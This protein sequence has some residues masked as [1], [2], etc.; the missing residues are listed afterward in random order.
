[1]NALSDEQTLKKIKYI[2]DK[3]KI[4]YKIL[5][6]GTDSLKLEDQ[7]QAL[8]MKYRE[9][10]STLLY[11]TGDGRFIAVFRRDDRSI[12]NIRLKQKL[13][14]S[15]LEYCNKKDLQELGF[16]EGLLSPFLLDERVEIYV[17]EAVM[18][19]TRIVC[20]SAIA[21]M[22]VETTRNEFLKFLEG[23]DHH[24]VEISFPNPHRQDIDN[25]QIRTVL[26]GITPSGSALHIGNYFG[27]VKPQMD[28][29]RSVEHSFY[30]VADLH[31]LTTVQDRDVL[32]HNI[33]NN[34]LDFIALGL[35][36]EKSAYFRQSD[37]PAHSQ[38]AIVLAN[39]IPFSF[40]KRMH[41]FKDKLEEGVTLN[42]INMGLFNYPILMAADILLYNPEGVPVGDDQ[43]QHV[44][45]T[46]DIAVRFN[47]TY[48]KDFF[49][50]P[51]P[52][53]QGGHSARVIGT[54]GKRKMSKS[55]NNVIGIF[56]DEEVIKKQIMGCYTDPN[57]KKITDPGTVEG[58]PVFIYH[59]LINEDREEVAELKERY[60]TGKVGDVEVKQRL[61]EAHKR[62]FAEAR[63]KRKEIAGDINLVK[64]VLRDG[65]R[66]AS[67]VAE[68]N[69]EKVYEVIGI[70]NSLSLK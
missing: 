52:L 39:Y 57:R 61:I 31:A 12:D 15:N 58:N 53:I 9:G 23:R 41:A 67:E 49:I 32:E 50:L 18:D 27:A 38:L 46:R 37:V 64:D 28:L 5:E 62:R 13:K 44:E 42:A 22:A 63:E 7:I 51:E 3:K 60:R 45:L 47:K 24:I 20:G 2:L 54:D 36:P 66:K 35:D 19:M 10:M 43:R 68:K 21:S 11:K 1:M 6:S 25:I 65:A 70:K 26:S 59:D 29:Q 16:R 4:K 8:N 48:D 17:T 56:E 33:E 40:L 14:V 69:I 55:L 30:F 34:V